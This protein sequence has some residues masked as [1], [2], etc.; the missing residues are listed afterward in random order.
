[1][2]VVGAVMAIL[3]LTLEPKMEIM[4]CA[5]F[6]FFSIAVAGFGALMWSPFGTQLMDS[7]ERVGEA[8]AEM[9][10]KRHEER[11]AKRRK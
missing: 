4:E 11:E 3:A 8:Q 10:K 2:T 9:D 1:M 7:F 5:A 6:V